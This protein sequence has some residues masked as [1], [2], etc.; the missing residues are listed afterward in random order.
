MFCGDLESDEEDEIGNIVQ[1]HD[2]V[3]SRHELVKTVLLSL[4]GVRDGLN[5][6]EGDGNVVFNEVKCMGDHA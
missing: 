3:D 5:Y 2:A 4:R 6:C 1:L